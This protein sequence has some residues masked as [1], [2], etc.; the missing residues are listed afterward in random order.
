MTKNICVCKRNDF[1]S[2]LALLSFDQLLPRLWRYGA[3]CLTSHMYHGTIKFVAWR[4]MIAEE[5]SLNQT[6]TS[7]RNAR[8]NGINQ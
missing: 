4:N 8:G 3:E 7:K 6:R 2:D 5:L 1:C